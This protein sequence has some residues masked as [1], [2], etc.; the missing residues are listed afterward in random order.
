MN[1]LQGSLARLRGI[2]EL[3]HDALNE[4]DGNAVVRQDALLGLG[5]LVRSASRRASQP[6]MK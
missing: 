1:R 4:G 3:R 2:Q 5:V 6:A